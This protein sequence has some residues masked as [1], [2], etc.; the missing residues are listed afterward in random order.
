MTTRDVSEV[1]E[2]CSEK[3]GGLETPCV[4][5]GRVVCSKCHWKLSAETVAGDP[6]VIPADIDADLVRVTNGAEAQSDLRNRLRGSA[7]QRVRHPGEITCPYCH[8]D[9]I[10]KKKRKGSVLIMFIL[11]LFLVWPGLLY[12]LIYNGSVRICPRCNMTLGDA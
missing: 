9:V 12:A 11:L 3:I 4:W 8:A 6:D 5:N 7:P 1:C 10:P 2:N